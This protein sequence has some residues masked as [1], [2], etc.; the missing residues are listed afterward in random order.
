M[1]LYPI[2]TACLLTVAACSHPCSVTW[3]EG[4]SDPDADSVTYTMEIQN[5]PTGTGWHIW[6]SQFRAPITMVEGSQ[7]NIRHISGT[8]Y[9]IE[10]IVDTDGAPLTLVYKSREMAAQC[11]A[12]EAF[13]LEIDGGKPQ[14]IECTHNFLP[15]DEVKSFE[16]TPVETSPEDI[17]PQLKSILRSE[18]TTKVEKCDAEIVDGQVPGWYRITLDGS[19]RIEAA[20]ADGAYYA[21][22]T[23][24][25]MMR[26]AGSDELRNMVI[27]DWPDLQHRGL[28][29]DVSRNFTRKEGVLKLL[30]LMAHYKANVLHLHFGDDEGWRIEID[31]L[32][33]LTSYGAFRGIPQLLE[34]GSIA[35]P[36]A[37]Q[38][39]YSAS[40]DRN[41]EDA[42]GNGYFS[43][44]DFVE[45]LRYAAERHIC[46]IPEFDTPGHSRAAI[47][48]MEKRAELTGDTSCLLSE[49]ADTSDYM[50]VQDYTDNAINV[51]L[52][53]TYAFIEKVFDSLIALYA[54]AGAPLKAIHVGGDE[55]PEGAWIGS[56]ACQRLMEENGWEDTAMLKDY[57]VRRV[58]EIAAAKGVKL[59]G[60][61]ELVLGLT[62]STLALLKDN[63]YY[64]NTWSVSRGRD[65]Y[66]YQFSNDGI[67]V[68]LSNSSNAYLDFAYNYSKLERGH[69]WGGYIDERRTFSFLPYNIYRSVRWDDYGQIADISAS[70]EGKVALEPSAKH[71]IIGVQG[72]LWAETLRCFDHVTYYIFPKA[73]GL[74]ERGWNADPA[75]GGTIV[76]DDPAFVSAFDKFYSIIVDNEMPYYDSI[77]L[78]YHRN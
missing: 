30:D 12:P 1:K 17:I 22:V 51:A 7:G 46:I 42:P 25:N 3:T 72:Q 44:E 59:A 73:L 11:R 65:V 61:Q 2:L 67:Q 8:L 57:Y 16:Y 62:P 33:E 74:F 78:N 31:A 32:P 29:L 28:M 6:Y 56:P 5:P 40:L 34:D 77:G 23:L 52:P 48:S 71:N 45:I 10:P 50:S 21:G 37:L 26:N 54:E 68:V 24:D 18:G 55:V 19:T 76:S 38:P 53:S 75:W 39:T 20:D 60:W 69:N 47:K 66:P 14:E 41:D 58:A 15:C 63:L 49:A 27:E 64:A 4:P 36:D 35:E 9:L 70:D 43:H 13:F